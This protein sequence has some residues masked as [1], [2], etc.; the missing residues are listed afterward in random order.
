MTSIF[1]SHS[2][3]DKDF[4]RKLARDI[5][6][7][8]GTTWV[9]EAEMQVGDSLVRKIGDGIESAEFLGVVLSPASARSEWVQ[10][11]V[12]IAINQEIK[13]RR[14]KVLPLLKRKCDIPTFLNGKIYAD[15]SRSSGYHDALRRVV[16]AM[17][18]D[19][20]NKGRIP[21][22]RMIQV[23]EFRRRIADYFKPRPIELELFDDA[24]GIANIVVW[25]EDRTFELYSWETMPTD[26]ELISKI[27]IP[28][29]SEQIR[30]V[31]GIEG[32]PFSIEERDQVIAQLNEKYG[33]KESVSDW[34]KHGELGQKIRKE[35][36]AWLFEV[37][38]L[39][40][41]NRS[42]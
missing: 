20:E 2:S 28:D 35:Y 16:A 24:S 30:E 5:V 7:H 37:S 26:M 32:G 13:G 3:S 21:G 1:I 23:R 15:F 17:G 6:R 4:V 31:Q 38:T 34:A 22:S 29:G 41:S 11:E 40:L 9:D 36:D 14:V 39:C 25:N 8:G 19:P 27:F 33:L 10:R 12:E 18:L 42:L